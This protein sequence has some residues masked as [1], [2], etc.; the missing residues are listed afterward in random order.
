MAK[1]LGRHRRLLVLVILS[2]VTSSVAR[3]E[4][5]SMITGSNFLGRNY[6]APTAGQVGALTLAAEMD[7]FFKNL[8]I[9]NLGPLLGETYTGYRLPLRLRYRPRHDLNLE[10]GVVL[11]HDFGD[12]DPLNRAVPVARLVYEPTPGLFIIAGALMP[13]HWIHDAIEDDTH[14]LD[15]DQEQGFQLRA[16]Q[17]WLKNDTWLNWRVRE[18]VVRAEEYEI[19]MSNQFRSPGDVVRLDSQFMWTHAGGQVSSS[20]RVE[21]NLLYLTGLS[22]GVS[23]PLGWEPCEDLRLGWAWLYSRD[24]T[25][26]GPLTKGYGRAYSGHADFRVLPHFLIRGFGEIFDGDGF[27]AT[28]GDPLY[29]MDK[30]NQLGTNLLFKVGDDHLCIEAGF[31]NQWTAEVSNLTYQVSMVWGGDFHLGNVPEPESTF[32]SNHGARAGLAH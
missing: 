13:T 21:Q 9:F 26:H 4:E 25:D 14:K 18:G 20:G 10:L 1:I 3:A 28:L 11:G 32:T 29:S 23:K 8:E 22:V 6:G 2:L 16:D 17:S 7:Y 27:T 15:V 19:G 5:Y 31:V 12:D 24:D 30:Y